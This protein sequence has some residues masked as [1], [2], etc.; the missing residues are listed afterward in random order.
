MWTLWPVRAIEI[1]AP[2]PP[3]PAPMIMTCRHYSV[4]Q[5]MVGRP[6]I[7]LVRR[8]AV[9]LLNDLRLRPTHYVTTNNILSTY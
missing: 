6:Y 5:E 8:I 1:A 3:R 2:R 7:E 9:L 4:V